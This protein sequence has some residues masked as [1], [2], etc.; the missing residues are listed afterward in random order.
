MEF[1]LSRRMGVTVVEVPELDVDIAYVAKHHVALVCAGIPQAAR[2]KA[3][4]WL[5][6]EAMRQEMTTPRPTL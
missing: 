4:D 1:D 3:A 2:E 6:A 5:L